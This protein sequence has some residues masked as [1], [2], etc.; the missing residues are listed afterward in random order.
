MKIHVT[1]Y[2]NS[3]S[4]H[5]AQLYTGFGELQKRGVVDCN[6]IIHRG[7]SYNPYTTPYLKIQ[8]NQELTILY[9][10][11]D[12]FHIPESMGFSG[13][14]L[15]FKRSFNPEYVKNHPHKAKILPLGLNYYVVGNHDARLR[16]ILYARNDLQ[17]LK[18]LLKELGRLARW[19]PIHTTLSGAAIERFES[20]PQYT[21]EPAVLFMAQV[22]RPSRVKTDE[23]KHDREQINEMRSSLI[24]RLR[25]EFGTRF[26]GGLI[27]NDYAL[28]N[29]ADCL[30]P[31]VKMTT[32]KNFMQLVQQ[33]PIC[34]ATTGLVGSIGYKFAEYIAAAR[35]IVAES[36]TN[37]VY[38]PFEGGGKTTWSSIQSM[39]ASRM[40]KGFLMTLLYA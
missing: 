12:D 28:A 20:V 38:G 19:I 6:W 33:I 18:G 7:V 32:K 40:S 16:R 35:A 29:Y 34:V 11:T 26:I 17:K 8:L 21:S 36:N 4:M 9:D 3:N 27:P 25:K 13:I 10:E 14:D 22:W 30:V 31:D 24:R 5:L 2:C 15:L 37:Q 23:L 39:N 1:L